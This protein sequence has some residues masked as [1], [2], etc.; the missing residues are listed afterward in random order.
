MKIG[1]YE[2]IKEYIIHFDYKPV[3]VM[4]ML[5]TFLFNLAIAK[6]FEQT[7]GESNVSIKIAEMSIPDA[8]SLLEEKAGLSINYNRSIFSQNSK[9][10]LEVKNMPLELTLKKIL[11]GTRVAYRFA[12]TNTILLYKLPDPVKPGRIS[13]K[14]FDEKGETLPGASIKVIQTGKAT[15]TASDGSYTLSVEPGIYTI[16]VSYISFVTQRISEVNVKADKNTPLD[17]SLKPDA[18]GLQEVVVTASY[19][20][21][22]VEGLLARQK[23]ASEISNGISAEQISRTP[24]KNIGESLKRISGVSTID[25]KFVIVRGIGERYNSAQLDGVTLPSTEAQTRNFSFDLIPSNLV[26]N[27]V[28]SK[29]VTPDMNTSFGG[30]L[31]QINTKDIPTENFI[32]FT[33]GTAYNDQS[34]GKDFLS[35]KRG[36]YDYF[37][38]D[39]GRRDYP[40]GLEHTVKTVAPNSALT[41]AEYQ[42]KVTDQSKRF[43][44]DN[45]S[46]YKYKTAPSQNYQFTIGRALNL[47]TT[48]HN[49]FGFTGSLSYRNTQ[50]INLIENQNRSDW[51]L[52]YPN[53]SGASYGFNTTLGGILNFGLQLGKNRFSF[54]NTYTHLYDNTMVRIIGFHKDETNFNLPPNRIQENEDP[55]YTDLLQNKLNGQ[56]QLGK[57]KIEWDLARIN[58]HRKEKDLVIAS[59]SPKLIGSEYQYFYNYNLSTQIEVVPMSRHHYQNEEGHYSW[60]LSATIPF[61]FKEI[62]SS[63]KTGYFGNRKKADFSWQIAS[64][65]GSNTLADSLKYIPVSEMINPEN[66]AF[67]KYFYSVNP[68]F[69]DNYEGKSNTHAGYI[70]LDNRLLS[71]LRLVWGVRAEYYQYTEIKNGYSNAQSQT[72]FELKPDRKW[73]WLPSANITYNPVDA[74]NIRAAVSSSVIRPEL[75]DNSRFFRYSPYLDGQFGNQ[76]LYSTR[77]DSYDFKTEWFPGLGEIIS[78]GGYYKYFDKPAEITVSSASGN[79]TYY[80]KSS[81]WAKVYGLEFEF[82]KSLGFITDLQLL[83]RLTAYG[84]FTLQRSIV[85]STYRTKNPADPTGPDILMPINQKRA[86]YG[87]APYQL[88][89][90]LQYTDKHFSFNIAYNKSAYKTYIVSDKPVDIEY[91]RARDQI[92]IQIAYKFLNNKI[93]IKL[94]AGNLLNRASV[95]YRNTASYEANPEYVAGKS[96]ESDFMRL[97]PGF[98]NKYDEGD[99]ITFKQKFGRTYSTSITYN[100]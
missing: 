78:I 4:L 22:S 84:N 53:N 70:M 34:T 85:R 63:L 41:E 89:A 99:Q 100:F 91:E 24:D 32:S 81:D 13:G 29:T 18:K 69:L 96:D 45:V 68:Y 66:I 51:N 90:G 17:I 25:N 72:A 16:E 76:G 92:D 65:S 52:A 56:H 88:N 93:E 37:G 67:D 48:N 28:V 94:N 62:R 79:S 60:N 59:S 19:K 83:S 27:V 57:V 15:Q 10:S 75:L 43:T 5:C 44:Q 31:I 38:F 30:G 74:L 97:K 49:K 87:Q 14:I 3:A 11:S 40:E 42:K 12:D 61:K 1:F 54:R 33:A 82:R 55:T 98:S 50:N 80:T 64:F 26:D 58:I 36:K 39:D 21:A 73:Q 86:M 77:I 47:D 71:N 46:V 6:S 95:F 35:H 8:L 23:N 9:I 2:Y 7:P 20:K